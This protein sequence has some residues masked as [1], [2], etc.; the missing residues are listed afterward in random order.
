M[1]S[2]PVSV[3]SLHP[4]TQ[5]Q[6]KN[7][8][9]STQSSPSRC[10]TSRAAAVTCCWRPG[11]GWRDIWRSSDRGRGTIAGSAAHGAARCD[12]PCL[13]GV[14]INPLAVELCKVN[15]WME[16]LEPGKPLSFLDHHIKCGNSLIGATLALLAGGIPA[17]PSR[18]SGRRQ[19]GTQH[20]QKKTSRN[21]RA[22]AVCSTRRCNRGSAWAISRPACCNWTSWPTIRLT[23]CGA[24]RRGMRKWCDRAATP[25]PPVGR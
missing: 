13:Y 2:P 12:R 3:S 4:V 10:V 23:G 11:I 14:D 19:G 15:L 16:A 17:K 24:S 9:W 22:S 6:T 25:T 5:V 21:A 18:R 20:V 7:S 1:I 8:A